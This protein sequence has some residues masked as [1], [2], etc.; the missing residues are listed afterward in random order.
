MLEEMTKKD[1]RLLVQDREKRRVT[2]SRSIHSESRAL[3]ELV[4]FRLETAEEPSEKPGKEMKLQKRA[5][6]GGV[7]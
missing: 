3:A 1:Q 5:G 2:D 7:R 4:A 6:R